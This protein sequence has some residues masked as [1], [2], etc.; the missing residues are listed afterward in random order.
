MTILRANWCPLRLPIQEVEYGPPPAYTI[1]VT[2][3]TL[4]PPRARTWARRGH[5]PVV[6]VS[7]KGSGRVSIA[8]LVAYRPRRQP[9]LFYRTAV[10]RGRKGERRSL[11]EQN[12][13]TLLTTAHQRLHGPV[14]L[15][16]DGCGS[17]AVT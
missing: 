9:R 17:S 3:P 11:S 12:Y 4:R 10:H 8:G 7:G 16:W 6:H 15:I 1:F 5:T 13:A 14:I 2:G